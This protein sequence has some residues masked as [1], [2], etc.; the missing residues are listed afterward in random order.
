MIEL[1]PRYLVQM[2]HL[3]TPATVWKYVEGAVTRSAANLVMLDLEDSIPRDNSELLEQG[4]ANVIRAFNELDW[5]RRLRFFRPR[6]TQL[7][8]AHADIAVI[9]EHAG[10]NLDGLIYPKIEDADEVRAIDA[11]LTELERRFDLPAGRV[12][13]EALIESARAEENVFEIAFASKRLVGL[14]LGTYDYWASLG[15]RASSYR[16]DH[17][18]IDQVR[19]RIVKAAAAAGVPAIAEMTTNYPTRDKTEAERRAAIEEFR[20]DALYAREF[21]FA[22][23]WTG[24]PEQTAMAVE[25]FQIPDDEINRAIEAARKFLEAE[26]EGRGAVM[27]DGRMS[28]RATDRVNRN[29]LKMAYALGRIDE[30]MAR[31][32]RLI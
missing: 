4:R 31:E 2:A 25:I 26:A 30:A 24:I 23:K 6:G 19:G 11:T 7:D 32:L 13:I 29:T 21:G 28:D 1:E 17:P 20:R 5:G 18:L 14:V 22:G 15:L 12:R 9:V 8:P 10:R 16:Y 27:I 3:T